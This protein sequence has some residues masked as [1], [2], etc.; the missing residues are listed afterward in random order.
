M[1][2]GG[3][4]AYNGENES[5]YVEQTILEAKQHARIKQAAKDG[6]DLF[7]GHEGDVVTAGDCLVRAVTP[8]PGVRLVTWTIPAVT[9]TVPAA[10]SWSVLTIRPTRVGRVVTPPGVRLV[11]WSHTGCRQLMVF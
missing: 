3:W 10:I 11:T 1:P 8:L 9:W 4:A 5:F 2:G 7:E 6:V